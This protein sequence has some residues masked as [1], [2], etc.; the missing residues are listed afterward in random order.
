MDMIAFLYDSTDDSD[1][2]EVSNSETSI[3]KAKKPACPTTS[4]VRRIGNI[5]IIPSSE[6]RD[7]GIF[8]RSIPHRRGH[9]AGHIKISIL[10]ASSPPSSFAD[11]LCELLRKRKKENVKTF[12]DLLERRGFSGTMVEHDY[13]HISLSKQFSLQVAQI[14]SYVRQLT[15]LLRQEHPTSI[16]VESLSASEL[17]SMWES[18]SIKGT[19]LL[20]DEKT[21]SFL[22]WKVHPNVFLKRIVEHVDNVMKSYSQPVYYKPAEFHISIASFPGNIFEKLNTDKSVPDY[23][24]R[25]F[26]SHESD[27]SH[28]PS[29]NRNA[30]EFSTTLEIGACAKGGIEDE[31]SSSTSSTSSLQDSFFVPVHE[32]E[33]TV[34]T[35]KEFVIPLRSI[36]EL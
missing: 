26:G 34:G 16:R 19:V 31:D 8:S 4:K 21:R 3:M 36:Q 6:A 27:Q 25:C 32:I 14:E 22:C 28:F 30:R 7:S 12:R 11:D 23:N 13:L 9:W 33:C 24:V 20:N 35:T 15:D 17:K 18:G 29:S 5:N 1:N 2:D 10:T